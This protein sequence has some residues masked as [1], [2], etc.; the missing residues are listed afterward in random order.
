VGG[1]S[2]EDVGGEVGTGD[3]EWGDVDVD[4][5][6]WEA[7]L[8]PA[9]GLGAELVEDPVAEGDDEA[10]LFG[11]G[12]ERGGRDETAF[13][14]AEADEGFEGVELAADSVER[15]IV[16]L[17]A[18]IAERLADEYLHLIGFGGGLADLG[19]HAEV[20]IAAGALGA[21]HGGVGVAPE[22]GVVVAVVGRDGDADA[23]GELEGVAVGEDGDAE[24]EK[25]VGGDL[26][27]LFCSGDADEDESEL[28]TAD[29]S[30]CIGGFDEGREAAGDLLKAD[31]PDVVAVGVVDVLEA[32]YIEAK[33]SVLP[34]GVGRL[35]E[36]F[37]ERV[38][39]PRAVGKAGE[40]IVISLMAGGEDLFFEQDKDHS[41]GDEVLGDVPE[42]RAD[43]ADDAEMLA[44][45]GCGKDG[46]P[47]E[48][49]EDDGE[50]AA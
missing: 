49:T 32:I 26:L 17:E 10:A 36:D 40:F 16:Q 28:F 19:G 6:G 1:E 25:D 13:G 21:V 3:L 5:D 47:G 9:G 12:D 18:A 44:E 2:F 4:A 43:A 8:L 39:E 37:A 46:R 50:R 34:G 31:V 27:G 11:D 14:M 41:K 29:A 30:C 7:L 22:S 33:E 24:G 45:C 48:E 23:G 42:L 35:I 15:L 20:L 38:F